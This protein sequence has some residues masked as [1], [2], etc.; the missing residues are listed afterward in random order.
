MEAYKT[1]VQR[2]HNV[3]HTLI[4]WST[5]LLLICHNPCKTIKLSIN[6]MQQRPST[7]YLSLN[8]ETLYF[9]EQSFKWTTMLSTLGLSAFFPFLHVGCNKNITSQGK[10]NH[11]LV[12]HILKWQVKSML[13]MFNVLLQKCFKYIMEIFC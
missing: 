10:H 1:L 11:C 8:L 6:K 7:A 3:L 2:V 13:K 4:T 5:R 9:Y 12:F